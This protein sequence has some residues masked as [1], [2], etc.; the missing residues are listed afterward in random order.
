KEGTRYAGNNS[1]GAP[2]SAGMQGARA[3]A[4][5]ARW[6]Q[7]GSRKK[8]GVCQRNTP[9]SKSHPHMNNRN[10]PRYA[11]LRQ[12]KDAGRLPTQHT[13]IQKPSAHEQ[14]KHAT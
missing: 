14:P 7:R 8:P 2:K 6:R 12:Q 9:R 3:Y 1:A 4:P 10:I 5:L 13:S 11:W